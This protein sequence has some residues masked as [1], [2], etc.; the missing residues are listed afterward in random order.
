MTTPRRRSPARRQAR[1]SSTRTAWW[2]E[3]SVENT[4]T[5]GSSVRFP[6]V[7]ALTSTGLPK[8]WEAGFTV[9]RMILDVVVK[10]VNI[11]LPVFG[12]FG[13]LV[14]TTQTVI[15]VILDN[16]GY[17]LHQNYHAITS[18]A[19]DNAQMYRKSYDIRTARRVRGDEPSL[20]FVITNNSGSSSPL[21]W[22]ASARLLLKA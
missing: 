2:N 14:N 5:Q 18:N 21:I 1:R 11:N 9:I 7:S 20:D 10:A 13:V 22:S 4:L 17:Y 8:T 19:N 15:D 12:A 16:Y 3:Q 6:L